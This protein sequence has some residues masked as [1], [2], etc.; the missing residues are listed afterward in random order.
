MGS[1]NILNYGRIHTIKRPFSNAST[2]MSV[3][4]IILIRAVLTTG[5]EF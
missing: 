3:R 5:V 1:L 4:K 2:I